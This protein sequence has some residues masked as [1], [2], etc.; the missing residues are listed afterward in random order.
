[1]ELYIPLLYAL[2]LHPFNTAQNSIKPTPNPSS[3]KSLILPYLYNIFI[4]SM[5]THVRS[6][7]VCISKLIDLT[8]SDRSPN[9][10]ILLIEKRIKITI[11]DPR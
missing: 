5:P 11:N 3:F 8:I 7:H 6:S 4:P 2:F 10:S 9:N 1:M